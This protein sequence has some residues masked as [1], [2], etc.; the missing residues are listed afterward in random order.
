MDTTDDFIDVLNNVLPFEKHLP[1]TNYVGPG[2]RLDLKLDENENPKPGFEPTDRIDESALKHD[3]AYKHAHDFQ[4]RHKADKQLLNDLVEIRNP[5][6]KER[7]ER[8]IVFIMIGLKY[9]FE[10]I[11]MKFCFNRSAN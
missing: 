9:V 5:T 10:M 2:T 7:F 6:C 1:G 3:L 8:I 11:I 4:S